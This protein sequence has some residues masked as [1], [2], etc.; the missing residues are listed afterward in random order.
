MT[1]SALL[2]LVS[3]LYLVWRGVVS[4]PLERLC[5]AMDHS[6]GGAE[7]QVELERDDEFGLIADAYNNMVRRLASHRIEVEQRDALFRNLYH[8][9][10]ALL[11]SLDAQGRILRVSEYLCQHLGYQQHDILGLTFQE[12]LFKQLAEQNMADLA[13]LDKHLLQVPR[14]AGDQLTCILNL[15]PE[16]D[17]MGGYLGVLHDITAEQQAKEQLEYI[18]RYDQLTGLYNQGSFAAQVQAMLHANPQQVYWFLFVDL[19]RFKWINDSFGHP[20]GDEVLRIIASRLS[21]AL[22]D[23]LISRFGGDEF[24]IWI[25]EHY[26]SPVS[27]PQLFNHIKTFT[28]QRIRLDTA[29]I[30][31]SVC[32]GAARF[33]EDSRQYGELLRKADAAMYRA[34]LLGRNAAYIYNHELND[35]NKRQTRVVE[36]LQGYILEDCVDVFFQPIMDSRTG[37]LAGAEALMRIFPVMNS[38]ISV[39]LFLQIAEE[40]GYIRQLDELARRKALGYLA[41]WQQQGMMMQE[42]HIN[43]SPLNFNDEHFVENILHDLALAGLSGQSMVLEITESV[44]I[45]N[46]HSA[47]QQL[48][49]LRAAGIRVALDDFGTGY[50]S[51]SMLTCFP[52]DI[53]KLDQSF[54]RGSHASGNQV[55]ARHVIA[56]AQALGIEIIAEG[57]ELQQQVDELRAEG[58]HL[59]QGFLYSRPLSGKAFEHKFLG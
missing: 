42:L 44:L 6:Y 7:Q 53:L 12:V 32:I 39:Q 26:G 27:V 20:V 48:Q 34:K 50:S 54:F 47:G 31:P 22:P 38:D 18:A 37:Q 51:L 14:A 5:Q 43:V 9:T 55:I 13:R 29:D 3:L 52:V 49:Q 28:N 33:P 24:V 59:I 16:P 36:I 46:P 4:E 8:Q 23:A 1:L 40:S 58:C 19:D 57:L 21:K 30:S 10:P 35:L 41:K 15:V 45:D 56:M 2:L 17:N 11:F 25:P